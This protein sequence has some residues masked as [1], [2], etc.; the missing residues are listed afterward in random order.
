MYNGFVMKKPFAIL[1]KLIGNFCGLHPRPHAAGAS[2]SRPSMHMALAK[3][4]CILAMAGITAGCGKGN[5][6]SMAN[7][8]RGVVEIA[9]WPKLSPGVAGYNLY[10]SE[11]QN[12]KFEKINDLPITGGKTMIP[13]LDPGRDYWFKLTSVGTKGGE[14]KPGGAWKRKAVE[15]KK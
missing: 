7:D 1:F 14:S 5:K 4:M 10:M 11:E 3:A 6:F 15:G 2:R 12:G 8:F 9:A 13:Y